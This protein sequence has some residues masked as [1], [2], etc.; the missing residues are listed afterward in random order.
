MA[1]VQVAAARVWELH[2]MDVNNTFLHDDLN[3]E[4]YMKLP[5]RFRDDAGNPICYLHKSIYGLRQASSNWF[6]KLT[7][8]LKRK[9]TDTPMEHDHKLALAEGDDADGAVYRRLVGL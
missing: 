4:V 8:S 9:L 1:A 6:N 7:G 5:P 2:Q 3:E